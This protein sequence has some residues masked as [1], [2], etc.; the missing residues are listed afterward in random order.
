MGKV[1][2]EFLKT[3]ERAPLVCFRYID[4]IFFI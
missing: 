1:V 4:D 2:T 3:Q